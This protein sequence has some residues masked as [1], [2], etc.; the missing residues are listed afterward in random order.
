M[1]VAQLIEALRRLPE[2]AVVLMENGAGLSGV[3]QLDFIEAQG[4]GAPAEVI[5]QPSHEE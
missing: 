5:L 2:D 1:T 3:A 4:A